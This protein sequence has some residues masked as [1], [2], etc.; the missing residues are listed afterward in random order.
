M[1]L[2]MVNIHWKYPFLR[3]ILLRI[4]HK[5][6]T[7]LADVFTYSNDRVAYLL[8]G[9]YLGSSLVAGMTAFIVSGA[10]DRKEWYV[11]LHTR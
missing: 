1:S 4:L 5:H 10:I 7:F 8:C 6:N 11:G 2:W 9:G 3:V